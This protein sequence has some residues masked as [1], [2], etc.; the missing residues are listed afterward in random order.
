M[1]GNNHP[2][3][4]NRPTSK[5]DFTGLQAIQE[6][7]QELISWARM[8]S[9]SNDYSIVYRDWTIWSSIHACYNTSEA[10]ALLRIYGIRIS[11]SDMD[12][13]QPVYEISYTSS[14]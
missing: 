6:S 7:I 4:I 12:D 13:N 2:N 3:D 10:K 11:I 1:N 14:Y 5:P 8:D 9:K